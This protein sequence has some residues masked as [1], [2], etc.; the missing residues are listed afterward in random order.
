MTV[1]FALDYIPRRMSELGFKNYLLRWRH[2]VLLPQSSKKLDASNEFFLLISPRT[3]LIV[4]SK[5]GVFDMSDAGIN[6]MQYEHR[7]MISMAN[8]DKVIAHVMFIQ[9]IPTHKK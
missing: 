6:E 4:K 8:T 1:E 7:G 5:A 3:K 9:V 2:F